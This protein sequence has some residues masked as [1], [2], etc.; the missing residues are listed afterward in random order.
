MEFKSQQGAE[1]IYKAS[2][3]LKGGETF[4]HTAR[5]YY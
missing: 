1:Q 5:L 4:R 2:D 3:F